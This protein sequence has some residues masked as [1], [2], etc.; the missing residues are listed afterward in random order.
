VPLNLKFVSLNLREVFQTDYD[1]I[2]L[3]KPK[4]VT[5]QLTRFSILNFFHSKFDFST[6][7]FY[8]VYIATICNFL[9]GACTAKV[10]SYRCWSN[11]NFLIVNWGDIII[12]QV[13]DVTFL[14]KKR[15][16]FFCSGVHY[17]VEL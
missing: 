9:G 14:A 15:F 17:H 5:K 7:L 1:E 13:D 4:N 10:F 6:N 8:T 16:I 11:R 3:Q 12:T 2:T